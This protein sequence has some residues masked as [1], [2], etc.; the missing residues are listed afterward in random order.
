MGEMTN[1]LEKVNERMTQINIKLENIEYRLKQRRSWINVIRQR[2]KENSTNPKIVNQCREDQL[3][4]QSDIASLEK[5]KE[6]LLEK[7]R[8]LVESIFKHKMLE[9]YPLTWS[10]FI[11]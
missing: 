7:R 5:E 8:K 3:S 4:Q 1:N 6:L 11:S 2:A 9:N 10:S